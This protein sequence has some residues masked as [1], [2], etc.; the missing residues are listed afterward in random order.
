MWPLCAVEQAPGQSCG[1]EGDR[2]AAEGA[3]HDDERVAGDGLVLVQGAV[4]SGFEQSQAPRTP[5]PMTTS[6]TSR[7]L[8]AVAMAMPI[9]S[10]AASKVAIAAASPARAFSA[11]NRPSRCDAALPIAVACTDRATGCQRLEVAALA[12]GADDLAVA[13]R[14]ADLA[15]RAAR[16]DEDVAADGDR[17]ADA[18]AEHDADGVAASASGAV[19][20]L[21]VQEGVHVVVDG[22]AERRACRRGRRPRGSPPS[23]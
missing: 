9:A 2:V 3:R 4:E 17:A 12:A 14:V 10:P 19:A 22:D 1:A 5:P 20:H 16:A 6:C 13:G 18:R 11:T 15:G 21:P 8:T 7:R 23:R